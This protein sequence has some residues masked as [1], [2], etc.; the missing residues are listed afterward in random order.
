MIR[1][2]LAGLLAIGLTPALAH[3]Q[4]CGRLGP[5][6]DM[7]NRGFASLSWQMAPRRGVTL[8]AA[9]A[10]VGLPPAAEC[11]ISSKARGASEL[12][13]QWEYAAQAEATAGFDALLAR[14]RLCLGA[15]SM[16]PAT[17]SPPVSSW[18]PVQR[19]AHEIERE[20]GAHTAIGLQLVEYIPEGDQPAAA[21]YFVELDVTRDEE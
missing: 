21:Q 18:R 12:S 11:V 2:G 9:G 14:M 19:N 5:V 7:D 1:L 8:N 13:C 3:A 16:Q 15:D 20:S 6:L 17:V 4:A 10:P